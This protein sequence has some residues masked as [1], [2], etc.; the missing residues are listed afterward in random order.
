MEDIKPNDKWEV[1]KLRL[2]AEDWDLLDQLMKIEKL[3]RTN[4]IRR[5]IRAFAKSQLPTAEAVQSK[6][7]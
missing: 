7:A 3:D 5:A 4:V 6:V 2:D 1:L